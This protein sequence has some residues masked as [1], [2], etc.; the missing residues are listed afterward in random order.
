MSSVFCVL[1]RVSPTG[2]ETQP[3]QIDAQSIS[4]DHRATTRV[5]PTKG[6]N[7]IKPHQMDSICQI[8]AES[9]KI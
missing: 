8:L 9:N 7:R 3:L 6:Q 5:A 1:E 2:W 4:S